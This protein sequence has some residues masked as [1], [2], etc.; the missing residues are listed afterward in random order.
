MLG[1]WAPPESSAQ[2]AG[3]GALALVAE[4]NGRVE[5]YLSDAREWVPAEVGMDVFEGDMI[6]TGKDSGVKLL[7]RSGQTLRIHE[8][9]SISFSAQMGEGPSALGGLFRGLW[10]V[11]ARK[12]INSEEADVASGLVGAVRGTAEEGAVE[13]EELS[14][15]DRESMEKEL[16]LI[17]SYLE[18]SSARSM[19]QGILFEKYRQYARAEEAYLNAVEY[20]PADAYL[21]DLLLD[22]YLE[23]G[24][25]E[26]LEKMKK[27]KEEALNRGA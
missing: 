6:R 22:L 18:E 26:K 21:Y 7:M 10:D 25:V 15:G 2:D 12:F 20:D 24:A 4:I 3:A 27:V 13:N 14:A 19:L 8:K 11:I 9:S 1:L 17:D 23:T 5:L 16:D